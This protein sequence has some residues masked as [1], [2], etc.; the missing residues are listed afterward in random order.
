MIEFDMPGGCNTVLFTCDNCDLCVDLCG[1]YRILIFCL[2]K[3]F[4]LE[5][6]TYNITVLFRPRC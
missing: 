6:V 3:L 1:L 2:Y 5:N 4:T